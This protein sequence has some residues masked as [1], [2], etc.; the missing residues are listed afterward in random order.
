MEYNAG[1]SPGSISLH[2]ATQT[3]INSGQVHNVIGTIPGTNPDEVVILGNH[4]D[5]WGPGAGDGNSGSSALNEVVRSFGIAQRR[6]WRP[7]RTLIFASF[8]GEEFGQIGSLAWIREHMPELNATAVAYLN[9]VVAASGSRLHVHASPLLYRVVRDATRLV[10]SPNQTVPGQSVL[11]VW[12]GDIGTPGGGDAIKFQGVACI[13]TVD[14][15]F[16]PALG[17]NVFPYHTGFDTFDWM[18][19][20]G[21]PGWKY[22]LA[23][24]RIWG[25]MAATL[26]EPEVLD[27][28]ITDY[29]LAI[30]GW[31]DE[32]V[33]NGPWPHFD[34]AA[35]YRAIDELH[36]SATRFDMLAASLSRPSPRWSFWSGSRQRAIQTINRKLIAF[37]RVFYYPRGVEDNPSVQHSL[38]WGSEWHMQQPA[39]PGLFLS[40][41]SGN[42]TGAEVR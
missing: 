18:E 2:L 6:G 30:R 5:A 10:P 32:I 13:A 39:L 29:A 20:Y 40:L 11:D 4:R 34:A 12:G 25:L 38:Y 42:W 3:K 27:V 22:H 15:G 41:E 33:Q 37:E 23:S 9:V 35:L 17:D 28:R 8:E 24:T 21:D 26:S 19:R 1:P 16:S 31:L 7:R 36:H 14:F